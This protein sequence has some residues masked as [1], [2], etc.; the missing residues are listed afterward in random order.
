ME[1]Y[2]TKSKL[3]VGGKMSTKG[4]DR[5]GLLLGISALILATGSVAAMI[6][7]VVL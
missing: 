6:L 3:N 1:N 2:N 4:A 7:W 5:V